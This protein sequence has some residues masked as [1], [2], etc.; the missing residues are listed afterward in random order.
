MRA[1]MRS[2]RT[3]NWNLKRDLLNTDRDELYDL[4]ND[5]GETTNLATSDQ[6]E[7]QAVFAKLSKLIRQQMKELSDPLE[8]TLAD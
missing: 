1:D 2:Y 8:K 5:P 3:P 4:R 6:P 7:A